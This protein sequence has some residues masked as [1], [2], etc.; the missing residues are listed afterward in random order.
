MCVLYT[1][2]LSSVHCTSTKEE[3]WLT[4]RSVLYFVVNNMFPD[5]DPVMPEKCKHDSKHTENVSFQWH[6]QRNQQQ[7]HNSQKTIGN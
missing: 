4:S 2:H 7:L 6:A 5:L 3:F 1:K